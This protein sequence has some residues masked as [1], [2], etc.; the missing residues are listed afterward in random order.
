MTPFIIWMLI[1]IF[2]NVICICGFVFTLAFNISLAKSIS[3]IYSAI[4][5][6]N[7]ELLIG[8]ILIEIIICLGVILIHRKRRCDNLFS[9]V[10]I[11]IMKTIIFVK[12]SLFEFALT[13][14]WLK[15]L[16]LDLDYDVI[17]PLMM[18]IFCVYWFYK[19]NIMI[20]Q[21][22]TLDL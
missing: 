21:N 10:M 6:I 14:T 13:W 20:Y 8:R 19:M 17:F 11:I 16:Y 4:I 9:K 18:T 12:V 3:E 22:K 7:R 2:V 15:P 1:M 5:D